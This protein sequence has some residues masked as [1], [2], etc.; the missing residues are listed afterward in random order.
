MGT[1]V[2]LLLLIITGVFLWVTRSKEEGG[3]RDDERHNQRKKAPKGLSVVLA[4]IILF[5]YTGCS[6]SV[7]MILSFIRPALPLIRATCRSMERS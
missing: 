6:F 2:L 7:S 3:W 4:L 1:I 5:P